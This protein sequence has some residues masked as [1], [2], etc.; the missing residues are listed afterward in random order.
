MHGMSAGQKGSIMKRFVTGIYRS[1][2]DASRAVDKLV[3]AGIAPKDISVMMTDKTRG[4]IGETE[5]GSK[6]G[7]GAA[8]GGALGA[9]AGGLVALGSL[10]VPGG[11][12]V[13]GPI[14]AALGGAGA[15]AVGGGLIGALVGLG[16]PEHEA[17]VYE[18][19]LAKGGILVAVRADSDSRGEAARILRETGALR[20]DESGRELR[21]H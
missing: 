15:G 9:I 14:V 10:A 20:R 6:A 16:I 5:K 3:R 2:E 1:Y 12:L 18:S 19:D 8:V 11:I 13:A 21:S 7:E 4:R 17:K